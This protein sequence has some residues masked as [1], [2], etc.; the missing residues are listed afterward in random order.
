MID[1][2][3]TDL[4][5]RGRYFMLLILLNISCMPEPLE[6]KGIPEVKPEIV[7]ATQ[8][9][10]DQSLLVWLTRTF[11]ALEAS[12]YSEPEELL[13]RIAVNDATV[14]I[15]G[16]DGTDTLRLIENGVYQGLKIPFEDG[17][18]YVLHVRSEQLGSVYASS[19]VQA[20]VR[21]ETIEAEFFY[22]IDEEAPVIV[23]YAFQD[24]AEPNWYMLNVQKIGEEEI[25]RNRLNPKA[26]TLLLEDHEFNGQRYESLFD[27]TPPEYAEGDTIAISLSNISEP[28]YRFMEQRFDKRLDFLEFLSEPVNY[29]SNIEGGRGFFNLYVPDVRTFVFKQD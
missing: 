8:M 13:K 11:G 1:K 26:F 20:A 14:T 6:V 3:L 5:Y 25:F 24:P 2:F 4:L 28:Y 17:Q 7:V 21:F 10:P 16:P 12:E 22:D 9:L 23:K 19:T 29:P 15:K 27:F 18:R